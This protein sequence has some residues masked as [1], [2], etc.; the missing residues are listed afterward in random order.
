MG[1]RGESGLFRVG[2]FVV[3]VEP[4]EESGFRGV[5]TEGPGLLGKPIAALGIIVGVDGYYTVA[6]LFYFVGGLGD[7]VRV[8]P[9]GEV[10]IGPSP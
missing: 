1:A 9:C 3:G 8:E 5:E 6:P 7:A 10:G 2:G 4:V